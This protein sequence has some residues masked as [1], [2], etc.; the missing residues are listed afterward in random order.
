MNEGWDTARAEMLC[1]GRMAN[2]A[3]Q[4]GGEWGPSIPTHLPANATDGAG[5]HC[6]ETKPD[7]GGSQRHREGAGREARP[8]EGP[9]VLS[10]ENQLC[11]AGGSRAQPL[12]NSPCQKMKV[13]LFPLKLILMGIWSLMQRSAGDFFF[14]SLCLF[15]LEK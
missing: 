2:A 14:P 12:L 4:W 1:A 15:Q 6:L 7:L 8:K 10:T 3:Q 5:S 9:Q 11:R 13:L